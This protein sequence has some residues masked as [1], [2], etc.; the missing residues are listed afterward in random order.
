MD[1]SPETVKR[2]AAH[3]GLAVQDF[4]PPVVRRIKGAAGPLNVF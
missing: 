4:S 3:M 1:W 2:I